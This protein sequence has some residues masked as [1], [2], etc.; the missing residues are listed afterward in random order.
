M[1]DTALT[2]VCNPDVCN[3][4]AP[5]LDE[6]LL[7]ELSR[8]L[9]GG[10][11]EQTNLAPGIAVDFLLNAND[12]A[13]VEKTARDVVGEN[14]I[15]VIVQPTATREKKLLIADMDSTIIEQECLD[16]L[17]GYAGLKDRISEITERA[18]RGELDFEEALTERVRMLKGLSTDA[19]EATFREKITL[20]PGARTLVQT[21]A[22]RGAYT[23]LVS[24]GFTF[25]TE[26]VARTAGFATNRAN[27]LEI[28]DAS[29][30]GEVVRPILGRD[31]KREALMEF[32]SAQGIEAAD[33]LAVGDGANDLAM[34]DAA[35][36]GVAFRAKPAV[37]A[38]ANVRIDHGDLT[39]LLYLQGIPAAEFVSD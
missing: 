21:M 29:L 32:A 9:P 37:A 31:A 26:K 4:E 30:T 19:L 14:P 25:F 24:G 1:F 5:V 2:L 20:T 22:A 7:A 11:V 10:E 17:A 8:A 13:E 12:H 3:A 36:L 38:A 28:E 27:V 16:E 15:D 23:A 18:M 33:A 34:I 35:G 6:A 39:A